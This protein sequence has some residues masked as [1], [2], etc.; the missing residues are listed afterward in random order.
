MNIALGCDHRGFEAKQE[1]LPQLQT[2]GHRIQDFGCHSTSTVDYPDIAYPLAVAVASQQCAFGILIGCDGMGMNMVANKVPGA[3]AAAVQ[4]EFTAR[5]ARENYHCNIIGIGDDL[6]GENDIRKIVEAFL[7]ATV[8]AG[9]HARR[10][11]KLRAIEELLA[12][13]PPLNH[14]PLFMYPKETEELA[15]RQQALEA[16]I[17]VVQLQLQTDKKQMDR[18]SL[19]NR[20][21]GINWNKAVRNGPQPQGRFEWSPKHPRRKVA[22]ENI[23]Q[24]NSRTVQRR[25]PSNGNCA[26]TLLGKRRDPLPH[27]PTSSESARTTWQASS[28]SKSST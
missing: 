26:C 16:Q 24:S 8:A 14:N 9:H 4:D 7:L 3:R 1:L 20:P 23:H 6:I 18:I 2:L 28:R 13:D 5:C 17:A 19:A 12:Q 25:S 21:I 27:L 10:V 22:L 11:E 15:Q